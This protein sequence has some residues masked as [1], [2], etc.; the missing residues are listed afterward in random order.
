MRSD[1]PDSFYN[2]LGSY[3]FK[4]IP[5]GMASELEP[6]MHEWELHYFKKMKGGTWYEIPRR[7]FYERIF[8]EGH[9]PTH[10]GMGTTHELIETRFFFPRFR[11]Y[12]VSFVSSCAVCKTKKPGHKIIR[13]PPSV[14]MFEESPLDRI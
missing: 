6:P 1:H 10:I 12:L 7:K 14:V 3:G 2:R 13:K 9:G 5:P 4:A 11:H 8:F